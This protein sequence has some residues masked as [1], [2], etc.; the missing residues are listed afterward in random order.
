[1]AA[2]ATTASFSFDPK[3][4]FFGFNLDAQNQVSSLV[5]SRSV[6][7]SVAGLNGSAVFAHNLTT[8][9]SA[10]PTR[11]L[12]FAPSGPELA[13]LDAFFYFTAS[14]PG[15]TGG[16]NLFFS[17]AAVGGTD[18]ALAAPGTSTQLY[19]GQNWDLFAARKFTAGPGF[20][21]ISP[22][23]GKTE[24]AYY[25]TTIDLGASNPVW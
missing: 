17:D 3:S 9:Q 25:G 20:I 21:T 6:T 10:N 7:A 22:S 1:M 15:V 16:P 14:A 4:Y 5:A 12:L 13:A 24:T 18:R 23:A 8:I 2:G 19:S 11:S